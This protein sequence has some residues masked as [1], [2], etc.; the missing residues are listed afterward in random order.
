MAKTLPKIIL[1]IG[2]EKSLI[3]GHPWVFSGAVAKIE[4]EVSPGDLG[5]VYSKEGQFLGAGHLNPAS[6]IILRLLTQKRE[7]VDTPFFKE[8]ISSAA[9]LRETFLKGKTNAYR[10][11]NGEG[12]LLPGLIVDRYG[13]TLVLQSL[14][15]GVERLKGS[16]VD[17]LVSEFKPRSIYERSDVATRRQEGL[18]EVTGLLFGREVS[19]R[20][21]IEEY[22]C[23]FQVDVKGGQK[24]GFYLDQRENR[25]DLKDVSWGRKVLDCFSYTGAFSIYAGLGGAEEVTLIDSSEEVLKRAEEHFH[26]NALGQ[27]PHRF[28]RGDAFE[29]LRS[30]E[31][32]YDIVI[33][34]PPAFAKRKGHLSG[35]SR[36]YKDLNLQAFRLLKEGGFLFTFSCSHHV[37]WDLFQKII[38]SAAVDG[39]RKVQLLDRRGHAIDHPISL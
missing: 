14:T 39:R 15:A 27:I 12:D 24:T 5:E 19:D 37:S 2:R 16:L 13:E 20:I 34:D 6:Q 9:R 21:E 26:L 22:G 7:P 31:P 28:I 30:L 38:F 33:L 17:L 18:P 36:G 25:S 4:G 29:V 8:R 1:K 35:A 11:V 23:H 10:I 32:G 3:R